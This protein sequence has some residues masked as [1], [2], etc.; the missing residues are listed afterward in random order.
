MMEVDELWHYVKKRS[1]KFGLLK[2]MIVI[3]NDV[4]MGNVVIVLMPH[5]KNSLTD[6]EHGK[7]LQG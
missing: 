6:A 4:L 3:K 2:P 1:K 5:S 7:V